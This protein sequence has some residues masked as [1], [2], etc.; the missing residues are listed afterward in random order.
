MSCEFD[1]RLGHADTVHPFSATNVAGNRYIAERTA[2]PRSTESLHL[3]LR[4][5]RPRGNLYEHYWPPACK[6]L[7]FGAV[8]SHDLRH[9]FATTNLSAGECYIRASKRLGHSR[10]NGELDGFRDHRGSTPSW[11]CISIKPPSPPQANSPT[12]SV[13]VGDPAPSRKRWVVAIETRPAIGTQPP[14]ST[15]RSTITS[16]SHLPKRHPSA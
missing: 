2:I 4:R 1:S 16:K 7:G 5:P 11:P 3:R 9:T 12:A 15:P 13:G 6:A 8:R 10:T 14:A